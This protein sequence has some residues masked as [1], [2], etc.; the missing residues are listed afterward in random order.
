MQQAKFVA[1]LLGDVEQA[2]RR[3]KSQDDQTARRDL[4]R[5][6]FAAIDGISWMYRGHIADVLREMG[7]LKPEEEIALSEMSYTVNEDGKIYGQRRYLSTAAAIKFATRL[8]MRADPS[9][10]IDLGGEGWMKLRD[11]IAIRNRITHP[12]QAADVIVEDENIS[13]CLVG[14]YWLIEIATDAMEAST[15]ALRLHAQEARRL[16]SALQDGDPEAWEAYL[17]VSRRRS[18]ET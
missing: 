6:L 13:T 1:I 12:K 10:N 11:A 7:D 4:V 3:Q 16:L 5:T 18:E 17:A 8:A 15:S 14:F 2:L 9:L